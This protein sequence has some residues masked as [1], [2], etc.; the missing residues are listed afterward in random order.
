[1]CGIAGVIDFDGSSQEDALDEVF[2]ALACR[3]PDASARWSDRWATMGHSRLAIRD[4]DAGHQPHVA[5]IDG[6]EYVVVFGGEI[7]NSHAV[8]RELRAAGQVLAE[9]SEACVIAHAFA[10]WGSAFCDRL[11]GM[12]SIAV[13]DT[14][15]RTLTLA[16]D[17]L[18]IKPLHFARFGTTAVFGSEPKSVLAHPLACR[19][20]T[21]EGFAE[22]VAFNVGLPGGPWHDVDE[23]P[24][25]HHVVIGPD[26]L[27]RRRY[28]QLEPG[29]HPPAAPVELRDLLV[30]VV[31]EHT[32]SD[33]ALSVML[34][35]GLDST[36][37][38][39]ILTDMSGPGLPT[40][41]VRLSDSSFLQDF[42]REEP[43]DAHVDVAAELLGTNHVVVDLAAAE[44]DDLDLR[45]FTVRAYDMPSGSGDRDRT[46]AALF[47]AVRRSHRVA[48]SGE[49]ADELFDGYSWTHDDRHLTADLLPWMAAC[50]RK[51]AL[52]SAMF[53]P[54]VWDRANV[55][56]YIRQRCR[57][58]RREV[59]SFADLPRTPGQAR[60][61]RSRHLHLTHMLPVLLARKDRLSMAHGLE[62]R[63]PYCDHRLVELCLALP[64]VEFHRAGDEKRWLRDAVTGL[65]PDAIRTRAKSAYPSAR[66]AA[67]RASL[68][69]ACRQ[70]LRARPSDMG[71]LLSW[72]WL[73][74]AATALESGDS[75]DLQRV[76]WALNCATWIDRERPEL[77]L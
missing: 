18:G 52:T 44:I 19:R 9:S 66:G 68:A 50:E 33:V 59:P 5:R 56:A 6:R 29:S 45:R 14:A 43:D 51:Y 27:T 67:H 74:R 7:Y 34:S 21:V 71:E 40:Y 53:A 72:T 42:E 1:M 48:L 31:G 12:F 3:G 73:D 38:A 37:L 54:G 39:A 23:V 26:R 63:V 2:D 30:Q 13:W 15:A 49:G 17:R 58:A 32:I 65:V 46:M 24:P 64:P 8:E 11:V 20:V 57:S 41:S 62:V 16:R 75:T 69:T 77:D 61:F 70:L 10:A 22:L 60:R 47:G 76:E 36:T 25:G 28:W 55:D 4:L 35:G